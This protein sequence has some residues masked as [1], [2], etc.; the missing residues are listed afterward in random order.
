MQEKKHYL[1][2]VSQIVCLLVVAA[3]LG[4]GDTQKRT[5]GKKLRK[6][7]MQAKKHYEKAQSIITNYDDGYNNPKVLSALGTAEK[8]LVNTLRENGKTGDSEDTPKGE[9]VNTRTM[10]GMVY[11]LRGECNLRK[12]DAII[13][14]VG[15]QE[16]ITHALLTRVQDISAGAVS[17][18]QSL[19][20]NGDI[21][22]RIDQAKSDHKIFTDKTNALNSRIKAQTE[23]IKTLEKT[24]QKLNATSASLRK[25]S[26]VNISREDSLKKLREAQSIEKKIIDNEVILA[27]Q[28]RDLA[29][30]RNE[31]I[32]LQ[33]KLEEADG[34]VNTGEARS[35]SL[36]KR[37]KRRK[38]DL[39]DRENEIKTCWEKIVASQ[40]SPLQEGYLD[41]SQRSL[42]QNCQLAVK[43]TRGAEKDFDKA[44]SEFT[45]ALRINSANTL[46]IDD[47]A[48]A[49]IGK[50]MVMTSAMNLH[51]TIK[52]FSDRVQKVWE[53]M[54]DVQMSITPVLPE[55]TKYLTETDAMAPKIVDS[56]KQAVKFR[57][58][59][60]RKTRDPKSRLQ[61]QKALVKTYEIYAM[62]LMAAGDAD[63]AAAE[64]KKAK[65]INAKISK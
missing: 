25:E 40:K 17:Y 23:K 52:G 55:I 32:I 27:Q 28:Q 60:V 36:E 2:L 45:T 57:E 16:N 35:L 64:M 46:L 1:S 39:A 13:R 26:T 34:K 19:L 12:I 38:S 61:Y 15:V 29:M 65:K 56:Y 33:I 11:Q 47:Q 42:V 9:L 18:K 8:L 20:E 30:Y 22:K 41:A 43:L 6:D 54:D 24:I 51:K 48:R 31:M 58:S 62:S 3:M 7:T 14:E 5:S 21:T 37:E 49:L 4:C 53:N 50:A 44:K 10:L 63:Q 59:A